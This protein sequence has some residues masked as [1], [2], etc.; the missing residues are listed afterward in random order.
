MQSPMFNCQRL[1]YHLLIQTLPRSVDA[2]K[3]VIHISAF[4]LKF[5]IWGNDVTIYYVLIM[6]NKVKISSEK[7]C[8]F[9]FSWKF[10]KMLNGYKQIKDLIIIVINCL[11]S[12]LPNTVTLSFNYI[13]VLIYI[14]L[15]LK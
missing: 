1:F 12:I 14:I 10:R 9:I 11:C 13:L 15:R 2:G 5:N 7:L 4:K 3:L 8:L 6:N